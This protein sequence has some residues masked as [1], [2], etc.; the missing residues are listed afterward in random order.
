MPSE[1][2]CLVF[3]ALF[4]RVNH[5]INISLNSKQMPFDYWFYF[6][7]LPIHIRAPWPKGSATKEWRAC[8]KKNKKKAVSNKSSDRKIIH[9]YEDYSLCTKLLKKSIHVLH[10]Q[11]KGLY[12]L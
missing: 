3:F 5:K 10:L 9:A 2:P 6:M 8:L 4:E 11:Q 12:N 7:V 1:Y